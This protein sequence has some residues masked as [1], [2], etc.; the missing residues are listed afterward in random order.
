LATASSSRSSRDGCT[1]QATSSGSDIA[2]SRR[3]PYH[4]ASLMPYLD[5]TAVLGN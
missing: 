3:L 4:P 2:Q 5:Y 1:A